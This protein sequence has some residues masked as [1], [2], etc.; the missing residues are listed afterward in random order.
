MK[1]LL[2]LLVFISLNSLGQDKT[3]TIQKSK[4]VTAE[5]K[6]GESKV[7][8]A[9]NKPVYVSSKTELAKEE[10]TV[11]YYDNYIAAIKTK[12][13]LVK[14]DEVENKKAIK[15]GWFDEMNQ[16]IKTAE[17]ERTKLQNKR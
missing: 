16:N 8:S 4:S 9:E 5:K 13:E 17:L 7:V 1:Y 11:K 14:A 6:V 12:M 10:K 2:I 15:N 3:Q